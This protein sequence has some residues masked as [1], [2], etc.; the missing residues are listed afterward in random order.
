M[1]RITIKPD[2]YQYPDLIA[3]IEQGLIKIPAFQRDFVWPMDS[4]LFL[5][6]SICR[7]YPIGTFL[8]WQSSDF[9]NAIRNIGNLDLSDPPEGFPVQYVLDGQQRITSLYAAL[10][11]A[12]INGQAYRICVDLDS[13]LETEE[14]FFEQEPD[15]EKYVLLSELLG[16]DYGDLFASLTS[17]RRKRFNDIRTT[18][19]NYPFSITLIEGGDLDI[20]CDLFERINNTAMELSVFDLLVARTWS[21][22]DDAG[23]FDLRQA[24]DDLTNEL[25]EVGFDEIP[26]PVIAQLAGALIKQDCSRKGILTIGRREMRECWPKL[27]N[28]IRCAIDFLR[29]KIR[30]TAL[31]LLPYPSLLVPFSYFFFKNGFR[32]PD[33]H[34]SAWLTRYFYLNGFARRL[35]SG[36]Q[37][38]LTEDI[39]VINDLAAGAPAKF[40]VSVSV[41]AQDIR[42]T[43]LRIGNA[44]CKSVLCLLAAQHPLD[45]RDASEIILQNRALKKANSRHFHHIFAKGYLPRKPGAEEVNSVVNVALVP[46][47]LNLKIGAKAPSKYLAQYKTKNSAWDR[48]LDS[49]MISGDTRMAMED[50]DFL[51]FIEKRAKRLSKLA[52]AAVK[53][54]S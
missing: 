53:P 22:P 26:K 51:L 14:I 6:D 37:S 38:K 23:G 32:N 46:A 20:V 27:V 9:I 41:T 39:R 36:T 8:F 54:P 43:E 34:Q 33:G 21:P 11:A 15:G 17:D 5:L 13:T 30:A 4:T 42:E 7:R 40:E 16:E 10:K 48:T 3:K 1:S 47:D 50:D 25:G 2:T 49:H 28:S 35:S 29:K 44:Y 31:R 45:L 24:V 18:F 52:M 19:L 12:K